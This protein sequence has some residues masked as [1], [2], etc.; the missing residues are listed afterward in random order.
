MGRRA[1]GTERE[2]QRELEARIESAGFEVV[3]VEWAGPTTRRIVRV[4]LDLPDSSPGRGVTVDD[5]A[6]VSRA[7]EEW[8]DVHPDIPER[9]VL[10][11]SS[12]GVERPLVRRRDWVRFAGQKV[13]VRGD[14]LLAGRSTRLE[15]E[16]L[17]VEG[18]SDGEEERYRIRLR[19]GDGE[20]IELD[21][22]EIAGGNLL[23]E[24]E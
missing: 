2:I 11:V 3:D 10:E 14:A 12:P 9:Y 20:E 19:L 24:W 1:S 22:E 13:A 17:G 7:L 18:G 16:L 21:R 5:C 23:F 6:T 8:L 15:G 4:R